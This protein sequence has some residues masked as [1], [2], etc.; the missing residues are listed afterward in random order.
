MG[1]FQQV[2]VLLLLPS[3]LPPK[4]LP[5]CSSAASAC[6]YM[7]PSALVDVS[8]SLQIH[9]A[10]F[11]LWLSLY[12]T[13]IAVPPPSPSLPCPPSP[14]TFPSP[15]PSPSPL[16]PR[17]VKTLGHN[18]VS[19]CHLP[20]FMICSTFVVACIFPTLDSKL[21]PPSCTLWTTSLLEPAE[22]HRSP[23]TVC[24]HN[25]HWHACLVSV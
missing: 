16:C 8:H 22:A 19:Y 2:R 10:Q 17:N 15:S 24:T 20:L 6:S 18:Y 12:D 14:C 3:P 1:S 13:G 11:N 25:C 9:F 5:P 21:P 4:S 23:L 7:C